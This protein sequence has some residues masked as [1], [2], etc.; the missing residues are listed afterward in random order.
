MYMWYV[1][2]IESLHKVWSFTGDREVPPP[3]REQSNTHGGLWAVAVGNRQMLT[4]M[5]LIH[6]PEYPSPD[7]PCPQRPIE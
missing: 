6:C 5:N 2:T 4:K 3:G 1:C 7:H